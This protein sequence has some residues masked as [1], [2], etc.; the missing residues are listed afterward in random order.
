M[1]AVVGRCYTAATRSIAAMSEAG[2]RG[3]LF[4]PNCGQVGR[5]GLFPHV[6]G[7][8]WAFW[9]VLLSLVAVVR[10]CTAEDVRRSGLASAT[11]GSKWQCFVQLWPP[12]GIRRVSKTLPKVKSVIDLGEKVR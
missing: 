5:W 9:V 11:S 3:D 12:W 6:A 10:C 4:V 7:H 8:W 1:A 2:R